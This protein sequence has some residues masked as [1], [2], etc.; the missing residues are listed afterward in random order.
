[1]SDKN[2]ETASA[3]TEAAPFTEQTRVATTP[4]TQPHGVPR[5]PSL[6]SEIGILE[7]E[8][9]TLELHKRKMQLLQHIDACKQGIAAMQEKDRARKPDLREIGSPRPRA[10][11]SEQIDGHHIQPTAQHLLQGTHDLNNL[12]NFLPSPVSSPAPSVKKARLVHNYVWLDPITQREQDD[13]LTFTN[14]GIKVNKKLER[15]YFKLSIEQW[16]YGNA[17]IMQEMI[18][19][20]ELD[21]QRVQDYLEYTKYINRLF[22][23]YVRGSVLLFDREYR[24]LQFKEKFRWGIS[25]PHLQD[26]QLIS[27]PNNLTM[28]ALQGTLPLTSNT[29][30]DNNPRQKGTRRG[31]F[32]PEGKEMCRKFN[33]DA[34]DF[35]NCKLQHCCLVCYSQAHNALSHPK[36]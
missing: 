14:T 19:N 27:K 34:C 24:E 6:S 13:V 31:P 4:R 5:P 12:V 25:R 16:G 15:E 17:A 7:K 3:T 30:K 2:T 8:L 18:E 26:F 22:S 32:T 11:P 33:T 36:N 29:R 10:A 21:D 20:H 23:K 35:S 9:Q 1:M 28:Q